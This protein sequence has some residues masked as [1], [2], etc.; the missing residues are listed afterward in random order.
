MRFN[1]AGADVSARVATNYGEG[2]GE[3]VYRLAQQRSLLR[4]R[5]ALRVSA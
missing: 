2:A 1:Q 4:G 3:T 5:E